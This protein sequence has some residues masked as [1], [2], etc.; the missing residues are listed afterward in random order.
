MVQTRSSYFGLFSSVQTIGFS[1]FHTFKK[2]WTVKRLRLRIYEILRPLIRGDYLVPQARTSQ[3]EL[4][5]EYDSMFLDHRGMYNVNNEY[6]DVEIHNN[7]PVEEGTFMNTYSVCDF[8]QWTHRGNCSLSFD[9]ETT[10]EEILSLMQY[11]RELALTINWK[12]EAP[13]DLDPIESPEY[14]KINLSTPGISSAMTSSFFWE[15]RLINVYDCLSCF[16]Q[17]ET[18][19]GHDK[20]YCSKCQDHVT[21]FKKMEIYKAPEFLLVHFKRFSHTRNSVLGSRKLNN[22]IDFPVRGLD[23]TPFVIK[24]AP[25]DP[26]ALNPK[27]S[28]SASNSK[29]IYDLYAVSNHFGSLGGGHYTASCQSLITGKWYDFDDTCVSPIEASSVQSQV[30]NKAAYVL[31]YRRRKI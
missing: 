25:E 15:N 9:E 16:S 1:R 4:Q 2:E 21:A 29:L 10:L 27:P 5:E 17:E 22:H 13:V 11:S 12:Y 8:C 19:S 23:L 28:A 24:T 31:F 14:F 7:L 26:S 6:Y 30:V 18:L 3:A 20:W